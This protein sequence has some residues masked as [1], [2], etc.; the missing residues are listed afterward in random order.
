MDRLLRRDGHDVCSAEN[1]GQGRNSVPDCADAPF[2]ILCG[3]LYRA[4]V[5]SAHLPGGEV[6][7]V[8][9]GQHGSFCRSR[10]PA[11]VL[12]ESDYYGTL[13]EDTIMNANI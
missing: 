1:G 3:R 5:V 12:C 10:N 11:G 9:D 6:E 4:V 2:C 13:F 7:P 8:K